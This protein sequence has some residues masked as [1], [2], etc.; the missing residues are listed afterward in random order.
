M[1]FVG[2]AR[3][4]KHEQKSTAI[5]DRSES[6][7]YKMAPIIISITKQIRG[8]VVLLRLVILHVADNLKNTLFIPDV[9][10]YYGISEHKYIFVYTRI[11]KSISCFFPI[12]LLYDESY[13]IKR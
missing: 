10:H 12:F 5:L 3:T 7:R 13:A 2:N 6:L 11:T 1:I 8:E 9:V 4:E